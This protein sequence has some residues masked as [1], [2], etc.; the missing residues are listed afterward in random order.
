MDLDYYL[1]FRDVWPHIDVMQHPRLLR[2]AEE[3]KNLPRPLP[4]VSPSRV[5]HNRHLHCK[6]HPL[7]GADTR[8]AVHTNGCW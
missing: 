5:G 3:Q 8:A 7:Q 4:R 1:D 2:S 6:E